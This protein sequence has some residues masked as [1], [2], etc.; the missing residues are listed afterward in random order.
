MFACTSSCAPATG[1]LTSPA[2]QS[3]PRNLSSADAT[4]S[5]ARPRMQRQ[6][7]RRAPALSRGEK[8]RSAVAF[9]AERLGHATCASKFAREHLTSPLAN[10]C[11]VA[12]FR[13]AGVNEKIQ[14]RWQKL[15]WCFPGPGFSARCEHALRPVPRL[16]FEKI[17]TQSCPGEP[18]TWGG[19]QASWARVIASNRS[20]DAHR[21]PCGPGL[22]APALWRHT[23]APG[24][25]RA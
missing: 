15:L 14:N 12:R 23:T 21:A 19:G 13:L 1:P 17:W 6:A 5:C 24:L 10:D 4:T 3:R 8:R 18:F 7:C 11:A 22:R 16:K 25:I 9:A 20:P 2:G